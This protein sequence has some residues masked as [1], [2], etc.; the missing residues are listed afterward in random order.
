[1]WKESTP[2]LHSLTRGYLSNVFMQ[3]VPPKGQPFYSPASK[4]PKGDSSELKSQIRVGALQS[5]TLPTH[6][7]THRHTHE[8]RDTNTQGCSPRLG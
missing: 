4:P 5:H 7:C 3:K 8:H 1:M 6:L 2:S